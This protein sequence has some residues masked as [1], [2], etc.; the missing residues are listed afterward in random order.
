MKNFTAIYMAPVSVLEEWMKKP[1]TERK[2]ADT[3]MRADWD[4]WM[5]AHSDTVLNTI[6]LGKTK[7][8]SASGVADAK[9]DM[10]LSSYVQGESAESVAAVFKDH[11]HL[12]IPGATIEIMEARPM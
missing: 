11:P 3:K 6:A 9:N 2:E 8:I 7:R 12:G 1:E 5:K 10:I 4:V